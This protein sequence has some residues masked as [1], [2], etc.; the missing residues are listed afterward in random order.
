LEEVGAVLGLGGEGE[1][2]EEN[3][4]AHGVYWTSQNWMRT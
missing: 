4:L 3:G 1:D 2:E